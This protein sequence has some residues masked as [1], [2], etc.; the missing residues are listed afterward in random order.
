MNDE[1][2]RRHNATIRIH[3]WIPRTFTQ[4]NTRRVKTTGA[5]RCWYEIWQGNPLPPLNITLSQQSVQESWQTVSV[6]GGK[7]WIS[8]LS[9]ERILTEVATTSYG[10]IWTGGQVSQ[11][12]R[13]SVIV[14][15]LLLQSP[16][17]NKWLIYFYNSHAAAAVVIAQRKHR[18]V[19][20]INTTAAF[21]RT[22]CATPCRVAF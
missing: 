12:Q 11:S 5:S 1:R 20:K 3:E 14:K 9:Q 10:H 15:L 21:R 7:I 4:F 19:H 8:F 2:R 18:H 6:A 17:Y 13:R 16:K 22:I